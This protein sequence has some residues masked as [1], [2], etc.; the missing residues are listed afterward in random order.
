MFE[1]AIQ[2]VDQSVSLPY[3]DYTIENTYNIPAYESVI[4]SE[5]M[6][7]TMRVPSVTFKS[8]GYTYTYDNIS[9][10]AI[11][12]GRWAGLQA[13]LTPQR[14]TDFYGKGYGYLRSPWNLNP[15]PN[16]VRFSGTTPLP[17]C[18]S[19]YS[20]L[21]KKD[22]M[23]FMYN[24]ENGPHASTHGS[25]GGIYGCDAFNALLDAGYIN[26]AKDALYICKNW[27]FSLKK[28]YRRNYIHNSSSCEVPAD[29]QTGFC[30]YQCDYDGLSLELIHSIL[31]GKIPDDISGEGVQAWVDFVCGGEGSRVFSGDH[32]ESASPGDPSFWPMYVLLW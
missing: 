23:T 32:L 18:D 20:V 30:S 31:K 27:N 4:M 3:W 22:M 12:D 7:G 16:I 19:H 24:I 9:D 25:M 5:D 15:S 11:V 13:T 2:A 17:S 29:P 6:F 1:L 8:Y 10:F 21:K 26:D 28:L 14:F